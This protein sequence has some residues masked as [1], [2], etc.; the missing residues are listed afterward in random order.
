MGYKRFLILLLI[1]TLTACGTLQTSM[2]PTPGHTPGPATEVMPTATA[3]PSTATP[4]ATSPAPTDTVL[5]TPNAASPQRPLHEFFESSWRAITLRYPETVLGLGL[6]DLYGVT[7]VKL[8]DISLTYQRETFRL[9]ATILEELRAYERAT[10]SPQEQISYDVYEWYLMDQLASEPFLLHEYLAT[11]FITAIPAQIIQ[12]FRDTHPVADLQDAHDYVTRLRLVETKIDQLI[13][14][15]EQQEQAGIYPPEFAVQWVVS[16]DIGAL[17]SAA[18]T[19]TP[20]YGPFRE[21]VLALPNVSRAQQQAILAEAEDAIAQEVIPAFRRLRDHLSAMPV[22]QG[23]AS[24]VWRLPDGEAYY[25]HR[26]SHFTTT[27]LS[28]SAIQQLGLDELEAL[29]AAMRAIAVRLGYPEH[30]TIVQLY[31]RA[32]RDGGHVAGNAV[33]T[34]YEALVAE[35]KTKLN[36]VFDTL[37]QADVIVVADQYG[38]Y[39]VRPAANGARPGAFYAGVGG[40]GENYYAMPTLAYHETIPGHHLQIALAMEMEGLPPFQGASLFTAYNE[41]WALYAERLAYELGWYADDP[42]G[43]LGYL[44]AQAFR[45]ARLVV[46][47]GLHAQGWTF[48]QA[49]HFFTANTGFEVGDSVNPQ[50]QIA[51]YLVEPGQSTSYYIGYLKIMELRQ[52][53]MD[54]LGDHFDLKEFHRVVLGQGGVPLAILERIIEDYLAAKA[55]ERATLASLHQVDKYLLYTMRYHGAYLSH[56]TP[57]DISQSAYQPSA[58][59]P[60]A[61]KRKR[62]RTIPGAAGLGLP[63]RA[64]PTAGRGNITR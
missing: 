42:Y 57:T 23:S 18:A 13:A 52:R 48:E 59:I 15:L 28:A 55:A 36:D 26:L 37:P 31:D 41:G 17:A 43:A 11:F 64:V 3:A 24:G 9:L 27:D 49:Q 32:A 12:L 25:A 45:A 61:A 39:Y 14:T 4:A 35:A 46:D 50:R 19:A 53:A 34:T 56:A 1:I 6:T 22:Y 21:K 38:G 51:R 8:D 58:A 63:K 20:F 16:G 60:K 44:Q 7:D 2:P 47:T 30:E 62:P 33:L 10:L 29:H 5:I 54:V 40:A